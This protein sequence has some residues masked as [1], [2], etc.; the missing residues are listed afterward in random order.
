MVVEKLEGAVERITYY[1]D[2]TGYTVLRLAPT[3][4]LD[5]W[6]SMDE[7]GLVTVVGVMQEVIPGESLRIEG[8]WHTHS[9]HGRQFRAENVQQILPATLEGLRRYL[10]SGMIRGIRKRMANRIID[11]FGLEALEVL[12]HHPERLL[13]V[14]GI[15][16]KKVEGIIAAWEE[17]K[18]IKTVMLFLQSHGVSTG[19]AVKIFNEYGDDAIEQ[20]QEDPYRLAHDI[21]GIGFKTAD[22]IARNLGLPDNHPSRIEA[23]LVYALNQA[24]NDG[25]V[26]LPAANLIEAAIDLLDTSLEEIEAAITRAAKAELIRIEEIPGENGEPIQAIYVPTLY[27]SE[28]G[29][30]RHLRRILDTEQSRLYTLKNVKWPA[31]LAEL[32]TQGNV[33][34]SEQQQSAIKTALTHKISILTGGPGTGKTTALRAVIEALN[35]GHRTVKLASPTGRAAKRLS[36]ATGYPASTIHRMLGFSPTE[37]FQHRDDNPLPTDMV[38]VDEVSMLDTTLAN[39]LFRAIDPRS[40]VLLV[41][42]VD[43]LPSVGPGDVLRDLIESGEI[44]VTRLGLIFRQS[45]ESLIITNAHRIN[46][47]EMP[48]FPDEASDFFLFRIADDP[49]RASDLVVDVVK[50]RIPEKFGWHP[51]DDVQVIVPMYRGQVGIR[52]LNKALQAS[53]N[54]PGRPAEQTIA[55]Q[56]FRV[57]DKV[58]QTSNNYD[59]EVFN[60]DVGRIHAINPI[61]KVM[62]IIFDDR[63]VAYDFGEIADELTHAYAI[64]VHRSQGSEYPVIVMPVVSQHYLLLQR[65]LLYTAI[66]RAKKLVVLVGS[67]KAIAIAVNNDQVSQRYTSLAERLRGLL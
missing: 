25:H 10:G 41:G 17:Q 55:G 19:L 58:L 22:Q 18:Q 63:F 53:L 29:A 56:T 46:Q 12:E 14:E 65:N 6:S 34:L 38:I 15:G 50:N 66:T 36:E 21:T 23:G 27:F 35:T 26:Y 3:T 16:Q 51:F 62:T 52:A 33:E 24:T 8:N 60:G 28:R 31:L 39:A 45:A 20:V 44:P 47:G 30:A 13:E 2:E 54:P 40:H 5:L 64:S 67:Q 9:R 7:E 37:G 32:A 49:Q 4:P 48:I 43:Q 61:E 11:H 42:D 1:N 57:G 59:K